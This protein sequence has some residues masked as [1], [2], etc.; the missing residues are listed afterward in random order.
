MAQASDRLVFL[1]CLALACS[2]LTRPPAARS[3]AERPTPATTAAPDAPQGADDAPS[4]PSSASARALSNGESIRASHILVGFAGGAR[5]R[6]TVT[7]TREEARVKAEALLLRLRENADFA[8]LARA[9][10]DSPSASRGGDLGRFTRAQMEP[11]F[12]RAAFALAPGE[13]SG[14]VETPFGFHIIVRTE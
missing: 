6:T 11:T 7:R 12:A 8:E 10:S 2:D 14:V 1:A 3:N 13:T 4:A 9:E 5:G